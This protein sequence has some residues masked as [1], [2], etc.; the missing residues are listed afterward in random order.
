M[1]HTR[2]SRVKLAYKVGMTLTREKRAFYG[3]ERCGY[4][5]RAEEAKSQKELKTGAP[6]KTKGGK[7]RDIYK[8]N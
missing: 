7:I 2:L 8:G 3:N 6:H 5:F 4:N 1:F